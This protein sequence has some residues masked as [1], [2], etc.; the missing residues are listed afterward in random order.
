MDDLSKLNLMKPSP[1][2]GARY[3]E[4][5]GG[6][7]NTRVDQAINWLLNWDAPTAFGTCSSA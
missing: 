3:T 2:Y 4:L 1:G 7:I 5:D 6:V